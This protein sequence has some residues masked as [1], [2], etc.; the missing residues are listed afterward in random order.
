MEHK[1]L[2]KKPKVTNT[3]APQ[4]GAGDDFFALLNLRRNVPEV[5]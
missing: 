4:S 2:L 3:I 5:L 1:R